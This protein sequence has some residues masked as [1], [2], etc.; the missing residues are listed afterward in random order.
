[1]ISN[2]NDQL[3]KLVSYELGTG[4]SDAGEP[5]HV[6]LMREKELCDY[7]SASDVGTSNGSQ[8]DV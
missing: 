3:E 2:L 8:K 5:P 6:K 1:M 4:A 7:E